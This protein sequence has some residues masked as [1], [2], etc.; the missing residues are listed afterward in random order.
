VLTV[1][2][3]IFLAR[4][5]IRSTVGAAHVELSRRWSKTPFTFWNESREDEDLIRLALQ[6]YEEKLQRGERK[7]KARAVLP[8]S[9]MTRIQTN[10]SLAYWARVYSLRH[11]R[12]AQEEWKLP[13]EQLDRIL[14]FRFP[15]SWAALVGE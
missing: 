2:I 15:E 1:E 5:Y 7:E 13:A 10:G 9:L 14:R 12:D 6:R 11:A 3:P 4:Q 8:H